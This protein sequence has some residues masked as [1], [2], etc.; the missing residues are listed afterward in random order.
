MRAVIEHLIGV[1]SRSRVAFVQ[2]PASNDE[3]NLRL[4]TY[5]E[6]LKANGIAYAPEL[7]VAGDFNPQAGR[8]A[9][10]TLFSVRALPVE[11]VNAMVA[12]NDL[13]AL[14]ALEELRARAIRVPEQIAVAGFDD[15]PQ[16]A[17]S[18][19]PLT[20]ARQR[21]DDLGRESVRLVLEQVTRGTSPEQAVRPTELVTRR[22]CGCSP[23]QPVSRRSTSPP[24]TALGFDASIIRRRQHILAEMARAARGTL[25]AAGP[26]WA[27]LLL[28]AAGEQV[29]GD[30]PDA[31]LRSYDDFLRRL[32]AAGSEIS[33]CNDILTALRA[34]VVRAISDPK[35]RLKA[36]D[37]FH[38]ARIMTSIAM[39]GVQVAR[40]TGAWND[41][42][43]L[44]NAGA[45]IMATGNIE[46]LARAVHEHLPPAGIPRCFILRF[47]ANP[48]SSA[49]A[50]V[51]LAE[52]PNGRKSDTARTN[53]YPAND[54]LRQTVL[55]SPDVHAF[56]VSPA[57]F[58]NGDDGAVI[59]ELGQIEGFGYEALR[60]AFTNV[61]LRITD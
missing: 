47:R 13:M 21:L 16:A 45:A 28:N 8:D 6:T 5:E 37:C 27:T 51:V 7:V 57:K 18:L 22:S 42:L 1:H 44:M 56:A 31:F 54:A 30:S 9:V 52:R 60:A 59:L 46:D 34:R 19:P 50:R 20:T 35:S 3:A 39:E 15:V 12:A 36:E 25:G 43:A 61:L 48:G 32:V 17:S 10:N 33:A 14:T 58:G 24:G 53:T 49:V 40:R 11:S 2:G 29:R 4:R 55:T 23:G 41:A 38:E 26:D